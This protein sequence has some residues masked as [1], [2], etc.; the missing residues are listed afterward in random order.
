MMVYFM[1]TWSILRYFVIFYQHLVYLVRGN[2]A[3]FFQF[4]YCVP[5]KIWQ[6]CGLHKQ[7][8]DTKK[9]RDSVCIR[10][11]VHVKQEMQ[12]NNS[13]SDVIS[14]DSSKKLSTASMYVYPYLFDMFSTCQQLRK[15]GR[16]FLLKFVADVHF[17]IFSKLT[18]HFKQSVSF[19]KQYFFLRWPSGLPDGIFSN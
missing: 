6:P 3:Y 19:L 2:L 13:S 9:C 1:D 14:I 18:F 15:K 4:W 5:R 7:S 11:H 12:L 17:P 16:D 10:W 8:E